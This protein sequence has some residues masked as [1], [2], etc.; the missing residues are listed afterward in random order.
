MQRDAAYQA[1]LCMREV[2]DR[3][4][5][6]A[7]KHVYVQ[8]NSAMNLPYDLDILDF[9]DGNHSSNTSSFSDLDREIAAYHAHH[10]LSRN[11][12]VVYIRKS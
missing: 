9:E 8:R 11:A 10:C 6:T 2:I 1:R 12:D 3:L 5:R 7:A 4:Q